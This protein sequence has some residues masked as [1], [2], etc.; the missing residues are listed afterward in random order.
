[1]FKDKRNRQNKEIEK[2]EIVT[3]IEGKNIS[4]IFRDIEEDKLLNNT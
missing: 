4:N 1:M 2:K 3:M